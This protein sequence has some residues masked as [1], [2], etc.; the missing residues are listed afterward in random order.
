MFAGGAAIVGS[1][2]NGASIV[3]EAVGGLDGILA[4]DLA[5]AL[6]WDNCG[7]TFDDEELL[8]S[9]WRAIHANDL[10]YNKRFVFV[11]SVGE[12][13]LNAPRYTGSKRSPVV[14]R[15]FF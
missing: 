11:I 8:Y 10:V 5:T 3:R 13:S 6:A 4:T 2:V 12:A 1:S 15:V 14:V 9:H 7:E